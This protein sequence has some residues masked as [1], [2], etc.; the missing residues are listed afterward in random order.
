MSIHI[1]VIVFFVV[2]RGT[3]AEDIGKPLLFFDWMGKSTA[4]GC[5]SMENI[6][7]LGSCFGGGGNDLMGHLE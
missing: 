6:T 4:V 5:P 2:G 1:H 7:F 3:D